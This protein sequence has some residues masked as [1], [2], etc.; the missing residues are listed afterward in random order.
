M[1]KPMNIKCPKCHAARANLYIDRDY[2]AHGDRR[3][4]IVCR[5]CG[6]RVYEPAKTVMPYTPP[7]G[8]RKL[9]R[10]CS[11]CHKKG[12]QSRNKSGLCTACHTKL[13]YWQRGAQTTEAPFIQVDGKWL[14]NPE[15]ERSAS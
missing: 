14:P 15:K 10:C 6:N 5:S 13:M 8:N 3:R 11:V 1:S 12:L 4:S 9:E 7:G 2:I